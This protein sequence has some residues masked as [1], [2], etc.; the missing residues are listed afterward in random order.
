MQ[1]SRQIAPTPVQCDKD[2][3]LG[4]MA[5]S[6]N[7]YYIVYQTSVLTLI[8]LFLVEELFFGIRAFYKSVLRAF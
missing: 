1:V 2:Q 4:S 6:F 3:T 8:I 5:V 7:T